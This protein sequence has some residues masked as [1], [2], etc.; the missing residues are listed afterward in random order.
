MLAFEN[1]TQFPD[2]EATNTEVL[3]QGYLHEEH[4]DTSK[5]EGQYIRHEE[6][7]WKE[8]VIAESFH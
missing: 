6:S 8:K 3:S 7:P 1:G 2:S 4:R 5:A